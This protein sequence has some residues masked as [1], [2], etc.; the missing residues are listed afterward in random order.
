[1]S[2]AEAVD[3]AIVRIEH[4]DSEIDAL[5]VPNFEQAHAEARAL[6]TAGP[7][8]DQPLFGVSDDDQGKLLTSR[9]CPTTFG[10]AEI[11]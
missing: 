7:G 2:A 3:A 11:S 10:H 5:A 6:D 4:L 1:M 9:A 8:P